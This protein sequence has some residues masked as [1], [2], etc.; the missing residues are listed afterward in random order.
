[1]K[2]SARL[3][4]VFSGLNVL[5]ILLL[6]LLTKPLIIDADK[7]PTEPWW[8]L[9]S[10]KV[11]LAGVLWAAIVVRLG[12]Q[13]AGWRYAG[14]AVV[15]AISFLL[16]LYYQ[17]L[18]AL[19][20]VVVLLRLQL[21][22]WQAVGLA[23]AVAFAAEFAWVSLLAQVNGDGLFGPWRYLLLWTVIAVLITTVVCG[24]TLLSFELG[25]RQAHAREALQESHALLRA[26]RDREI[27]HAHLEERTRISRELHDTL[28]HQLTAQRFELQA[29]ARLL[30][31]EAG[32]A[33][34]VLGRVLDRNTEA[35]AD[36]R[37]AVQA[38]RPDVI[39]A[40]LAP[41]L[42]ALLRDWGDANVT[43]RIDGT[44]S[45][46]S[47]DAQL[48]VYRAAQEALTNARKH[49]PGQPLTLHVTFGA[50]D[51]TLTARNPAPD[52]HPTPVGGQGIAGLR[53]RAAHLGGAA[54]GTYGEGE[55]KL[56]MTVKT[57]GAGA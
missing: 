6:V 57:N 8:V 55:F 33:R 17:P 34:E 3:A 4:A 51:V 45:H 18:L 27:R 42:R 24:Y 40:G 37:R 54:G 32:S 11:L 12:S 56:W 47:Q 52:A 10:G 30:P 44:E 1:M 39:G 21:G 38:L 25:V 43:L 19:V 48:A 46:V 14:T 9:A 5:M 20:Y 16:S 50:G 31:E 49:A 29:L 23:L 41:A 28:G 53:E 26:Y 22:F 2:P 15:A 36:V 13:V 35:I 7:L